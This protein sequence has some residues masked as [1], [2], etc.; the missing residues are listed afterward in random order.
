MSARLTIASRIAGT[1]RA[2]L[3]KACRHID[4]CRHYKSRTR[5]GNGQSHALLFCIQVNERSIVPE[6]RDPAE[7]VAVDHDMADR[8][9]RHMGGDQQFSRRRMI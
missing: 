1:A 9:K 3:R 6:H 5:S 2:V 8:R 4:P 7:G